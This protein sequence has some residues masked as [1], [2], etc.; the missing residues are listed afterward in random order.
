MDKSKLENELLADLEITIEAGKERG[1]VPAYFMQMLSEHGALKT[2]QKLLS[3]DA[4][5]EGLFRL[6]G[7]E[8]LHQSLEAVVLKPKY[9]PLFNDD[10][11]QRAES[12]LRD[13]GYSVE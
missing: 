12:R 7:L 11:L 3:S 10:E 5:Q 6:H 1:Y 13:L 2:A 4:P 8:L 9:K